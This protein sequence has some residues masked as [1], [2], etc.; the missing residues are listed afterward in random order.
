MILEGKKY[1][2]LTNIGTKPTVSDHEIKGVETYIYDFNEDV[3]GLEAE[4]YLKHFCRPEVKFDSLE[5]LKAQLLSDI[6]TWKA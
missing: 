6:E 1:R 2:G 4:V 5:D 3:Y